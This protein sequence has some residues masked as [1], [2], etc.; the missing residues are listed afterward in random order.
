MKKEYRL[1]KNEDFQKVYKQCKTIVDSTYKVSYCKNGL[2]HIRVGISVS[3]KIGNSV[4]RHKVRRQ[5]SEMM[6][7]LCN[8]NLDY[9]IIIVAKTSF[10]ENGFD[11]NYQ[12]IEK[13][14]QRIVEEN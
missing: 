1:R 10:L 5:I 12:K 14:Y 8:L 2:D 9:D 7:K 11:I 6:Q 13:L 3:K 4:V